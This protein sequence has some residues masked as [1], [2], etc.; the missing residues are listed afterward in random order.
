M[1]TNRQKNPPRILPCRDP[2]PAPLRTPYTYQAVMSVY[3][4]TSVPCRCLIQQQFC[5]TCG[6]LVNQLI[7]WDPRMTGRAASEQW[8]RMA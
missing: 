6:G 3:P 7:E 5:S 1:F 2:K 8:K 4:G